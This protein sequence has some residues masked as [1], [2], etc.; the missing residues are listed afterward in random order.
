MQGKG[1]ETWLLFRSAG[2]DN[3]GS[4]VNIGVDERPA[5]EARRSVGV[6]RTSPA[7]QFGIEL[8]VPTHRRRR[9]SGRGC[10]AALA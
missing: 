9:A 1:Y 7:V 6:R 5:S 10:Q 3:F 4:S 2:P 8:G